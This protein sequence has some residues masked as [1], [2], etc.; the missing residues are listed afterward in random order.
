MNIQIAHGVPMIEIK[1]E[2]RGKRR[3]MKKNNRWIKETIETKRV[4]IIKART[5]YASEPCVR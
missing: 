5:V 2:D 1:T 3:K 4:I